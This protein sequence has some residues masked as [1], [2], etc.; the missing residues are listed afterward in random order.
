M[1]STDQAAIA[2]HTLSQPFVE[3]LAQNRLRWQRCADCGAA[4][5]LSRL[6]C[7]ACGSAALRWQDAAG[8]AVVK[9]ASTVWRAPSPEFKPLVPYV[10]VIVQLTEGSRLM[11]H[12]APG[13]QVGHTVRATFFAHG[14]RTLLR[15]VAD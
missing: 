3:G 5:H 10:L 6:A 1:T 12:A 13:V 7:R 15:F 11:G 9:A 4:Q 2:S 14:D 8:T